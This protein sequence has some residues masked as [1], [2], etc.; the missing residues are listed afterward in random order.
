MGQEDQRLRARAG[1]VIP[2]GM[3]GHQ[4]THLLPAS[5]PQ[6]FRRA[7]GAHLWD[8][9]GKRYLDLMC[10]YGPNLFGYGDRDI[11]AAFARQLAQGDTMTGPSPV[12][13]DW[14]ERMVAR[15][16]HADWVMPCKNGTDATT[17]AMTIA[18][19]ATG[20][21]RVLLADGAYHGAAPWATPV[22]A[23]TLPEDRA[24]L[25]YFR[26]NDIADLERAVAQAGDDL[27]AVMAA[28]FRHD[29]FT[30]QEQPSAA[31]AQAVR[32]LCD[33]AGALL[34]VDDV[35]CGFRLARGCSWE[36][37]NVAP[38]LSCWGKAIANGHPLSMLAG[39]ERTRQAAR[40][41]YAT[42][43]FWF[44]AAPMAAS[45]AVL[46]RVE[47]SDYLA[48]LTALGQRLRSGLAEAARRSG[49]ALSQTGPVVMPLVLVADD[50][51]FRLGFALGE[52]LLD[53]G[54][55]WHPWHNMF[56][57]AAMTAADIDMVV[58]A[59]ADALPAIAAG[60]ERLRPHPV[61]HAMLTAGH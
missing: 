35:R 14:A 44:S 24:H 8:A 10:A 46:D 51:D 11:D 18:R 12:M 4:A 52:A 40:A 28:P 22:R 19:A 60:R 27:A 38:D 26:Y 7:Q 36:P 57:C 5:Y 32:A 55:Y 48:H 45:L 37:F 58:A 6:F 33:R 50:P 61:V 17:M 59:A 30:N 23:G 31:Y 15:I 2:G 43:S 56:L 9:D 1:R 41:I 13:V 49:L 39:N 16:A 25:G 53:R 42:G 29:A 54:I 3:F 21:R 20:R 47:A 34:V